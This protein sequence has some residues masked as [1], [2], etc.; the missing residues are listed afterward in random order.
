MYL[1]I[2][3]CALV[4]IGSTLMGFI[5]GENLK[6]RFQQLKEI[7]QALY[8]LKS[9][10]IYTHSTLPEIFENVSSKSNKPINKL[11][12]DISEL[13]YEN[14]VENVFQAF[15]KALDMNKNI[16]NL[17]EADNEILLDLSKSLGQSDIEG[18][19]NIISLTINKL[20]NQLEGA[21]EV[22]K[23]NIKMYRYMGFSFGAIVVIMII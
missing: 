20:E 10:I 21:E 5:L 17:K 19:N 6:K 9:E 13:L 1:K 2:L 12:K 4:L 15:T 7:E 23:N 14:K 22:M 8:Q 3:G 16:L 18:Q 11:F